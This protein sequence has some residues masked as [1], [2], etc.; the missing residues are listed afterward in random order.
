MVWF[1]FRCEDSGERIVTRTI[2]KRQFTELNFQNIL[3]GFPLW[4]GRF[5]RREVFAEQ[6]YL[7]PEFANC[8]DR[9]FV[10]RL[11][12]AGIEDRPLGCEVEWFRVH[13][14]SRTTNTSGER[15]SAF[16]SSHLS[17]ALHK[18]HCQ[19][20]IPGS[21]RIFRYWYARELYRL[22]LRLGRGRE[23]S[24]IRRHLLDAFNVDPLW[25]IRGLSV[26]LPSV[27]VR[28]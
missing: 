14:G 8:N 2:A 7:D 6:G 12:E 19:E 15:A 4:S 11:V 3:D 26:F 24:R 18:L 13:E 25:P 1:F 27:R 9:E 10:L 28:R 22:I 23:W 20:K 17:L 16:L 21:H 5:Y